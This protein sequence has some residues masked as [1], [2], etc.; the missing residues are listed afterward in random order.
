MHFQRVMLFCIQSKSIFFHG[1]LP[2]LQI[3]QNRL[4]CISLWGYRTSNDT[5]LADTFKDS[6]LTLQALN[7][8]QP[9]R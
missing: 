4:E 7:K 1:D 2:Q 8:F 6:A 9:Q 5:L 3:I